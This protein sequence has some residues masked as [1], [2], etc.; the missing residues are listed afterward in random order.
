MK[1]GNTY[2]KTVQPWELP[3][4]VLSEIYLR[5]LESNKILDILLKYHII[6]YFRYVD[7]ILIVYNNEMTDIKEVLHS[8]NNITPT[9]TFT[10]EEEI[11]NVNFLGVTSSKDEHKISF[12]L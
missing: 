5:Y 4:R 8:F 2:E 10:T 6:G 11:N 3:H 12:N 7:D 9:M 1:I